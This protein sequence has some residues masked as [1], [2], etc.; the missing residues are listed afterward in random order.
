MSLFLTFVFAFG[1]RKKRA[2]CLLLRNQR[3]SLDAIADLPREVIDRMCQSELIDLIR[4][5][6]VLLLR[7]E[8]QKRIAVIERATLMKLVYKIRQCVRQRGYGTGT[9]QVP[10]RGTA[11]CNAKPR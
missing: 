9:V 10:D 1:L 7:P 3:G 6:E 2:E 4:H 5:S 11:K 8:T